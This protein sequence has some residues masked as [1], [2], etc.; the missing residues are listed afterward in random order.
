MTA[1]ATIEEVVC[2]RSV[3]ST[4]FDLP[5]VIRDLFR[6][7]HQL[8][9]VGL[10]HQLSGIGGVGRMGQ[11]ALDEVPDGL[12]AIGTVSSGPDNPL[13]PCGTT[14]EAGAENRIAVGITALVDGSQALLPWG[15][16]EVDPVPAEIGR[17]CGECR[18]M[19]CDSCPG[20]TAANRDRQ[21]EPH[22]GR[23]ARS[24]RPSLP[25]GGS[26]LRRLPQP[27]AVHPGPGA[28]RAHSPCLHRPS[29]G[30]ASGHRCVLSR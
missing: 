22:D 21:W 7:G 5:A 10:V 11:G 6:L 1:T 9:G 24:A 3:A 17:H 28:G 16:E 29:G 14:A 4:D 8:P 27:E 20:R 25:G 13:G 30:P 26:T 19:P 12:R 18:A 23:P 15:R 2:L